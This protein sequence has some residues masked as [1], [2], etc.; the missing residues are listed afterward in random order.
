MRQVLT[1]DKGSLMT[2]PIEAEGVTTP[3]IPSS[4]P[5]FDSMDI[6]PLPH[7]APHFSVTLPSPS[8]E[9]TP[10]LS[11]DV[12][13]AENTREQRALVADAAPAPPSF[14]QLPEYAN[15]TLPASVQQLTRD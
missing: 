3:P 8:P 4:S 7:K 2:P 15:A 10:M 13:A 14:L 9:G 5:C 6:S 12:S 11:G 1:L